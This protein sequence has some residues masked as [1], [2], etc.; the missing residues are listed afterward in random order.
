MSL[1]TQSETEYSVWKLSLSDHDQA[2]NFPVRLVAE[3]LI[4]KTTDYSLEN[5]THLYNLREV[6]ESRFN[7]DA[8]DTHCG[9]L[10]AVKNNKMRESSSPLGFSL[11]CSRSLEYGFAR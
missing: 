9:P 11:L 2:G 3:S 6:V 8:E 1:N 10:A 4:L 5:N 7:N